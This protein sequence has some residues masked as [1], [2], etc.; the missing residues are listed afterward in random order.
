MVNLI[1]LTIRSGGE[2]RWTDSTVTLAES[3]NYAEPTNTT[4]T[5]TGKW[6]VRRG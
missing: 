5:R 2:N 6:G 4:I 1:C 3:S